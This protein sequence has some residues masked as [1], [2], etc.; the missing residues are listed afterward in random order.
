[1]VL[2]HGILEQAE[3]KITH[4]PCEEKNSQQKHR[5]P[6]NFIGKDVDRKNGTD[7]D[8]QP[9]Y[10]FYCRESFIGV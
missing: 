4:S 9:Q 1:M 5:H 6:Q 10:N 2:F 7:Q 3:R 8:C